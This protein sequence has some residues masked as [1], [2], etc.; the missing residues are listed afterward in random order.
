MH[1]MNEEFFDKD[2]FN[3][4]PLFTSRRRLTD[5]EIDE[6]IQRFVDETL[7]MAEAEAAMERL[8]RAEKRVLPRLLSLIASPD[9]HLHQ[10]A[11]VLVR[12]MDFTKAIEPLHKLLEDPDLEDDH[13]MSILHALD[14]LGGLPPDENP[15]VYLRDPE[16]M[17]QKTQEATLN[18]FQDPLE[19]ETVLQTIVAGNVAIRDNP[20]I[21]PAMA[22]IQDRRLLPLLLCLLHASDD[23]IVI[24]AIDALTVLNDASVVPILKERAL[25]DPV[26]D[27]R[28]AAQEAA[29]EL[30]FDP[31]A[32]R[33]TSIFDLPVA[34]PPLVR[35]LISTIDGN[36]GQVLVIVRQQPDGERGYLFWDV[37]FNDHEGIK[38][39]FGGQSHDD[40]EIEAVI[41]DGLAE[42]GIETLE[43]GLER[44]RAE[45]ERAYQITLEAN[46]R[47]PVSYMGWQSWLQGEDDEPV[48]VFPL[49]EVTPEEQATLFEHC[50]DLTDLDEFESWFFDPDEL[51]GL[52]RRFRQ[53]MERRTAQEAIEKLVSKAIKNVVNDKRRRLLHRRLERQAWLLAQIYEGDEIPK[54]V[55][56]AAAGLSDEAGAG[57]EQHPLLREMMFNSFF[58]AI[59]WGL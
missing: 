1:A 26:P 4:D 31:A 19:L 57:L 9:P 15:F 3:I 27:V 5:A 28:Y 24:G 34:P 36:G 30:D 8:A 48:E 45:L 21:L 29:D 54:L 32:S 23:D 43:I 46:R 17:F 37:M 20:N 51:H 53:L 44:A 49:P 11:I 41:V 56:A 38:D 52:E 59:G 40:E 39:C 18:S 13:K 22:D 42:I 14:A 33:P 50:D 25:Y 2:F 7:N 47:L 12:E 35:C 10:T 55:L 16:A 6:I 58:N